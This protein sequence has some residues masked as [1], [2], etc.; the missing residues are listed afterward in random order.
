VKAQRH[1]LHDTPEDRG[2]IVAEVQGGS[3]TAI[4][5]SLHQKGLV[6]GGSVGSSD[7]SRCPDT[8]LRFRCTEMMDF[9]QKGWI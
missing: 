5:L 8:S 7:V 2:T 4:S 9:I 3:A 1:I 6:L